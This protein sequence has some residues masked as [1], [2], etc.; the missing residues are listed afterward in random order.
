MDR[1]EFYLN[2][3]LQSI[4][5]GSGP[6]YKW[7]F[8]YHGDLHIDVRAEG[9]DIAG[10]MAIDIVEDPVL[11]D[12]NRN[13]LQQSQIDTNLYVINKILNISNMIQKE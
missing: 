13:N 12:F 1:V 7:S 10:N 6:T 8:T 3:I 4:V 5:S 2:K 11:T 9:Y